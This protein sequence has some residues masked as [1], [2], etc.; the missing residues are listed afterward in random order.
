MNFLQNKKV[1]SIIFMILCVLSYT[2]MNFVCK[3]FSNELTAYQLLF[4]RSFPSVLI[5]IFAMRQKKIS[6]LGNSKGF[7]FLRALAG[8]LSALFFFEAIKL[9]P[10]GTSMILKNLEPFFALLLSFA[11]L[12]YK[13]NWVHFYAILFALLGI[14]IVL[15]NSG[16]L[17]IEGITYMT[18]SALI[19]GFAIVFISKIGN[20]DSPLTVVFYLSIFCTLLGCLSFFDWKPVP[21]ELYF[22]LFLIGILNF[23]AQLFLTLSFQLGDPRKVA[24]IKYVEILLAMLLG[25]FLLG[26]SYVAYNYIGAVILIFALVINIMDVNKDGKINLKD[27]EYLTDFDKN[28]FDL[29]KDGKINFKDFLFFFKK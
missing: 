8:T 14:F 28:K 13:F 3:F 23:I 21:L 24:P 15:F 17:S 19:G 5:C 9:L 29:N 11:F 6:F 7:L 2:L 10:I 26:E 16:D 18:I 22:Y 12:G 25:T 4:F 27:F 1:L 20:K